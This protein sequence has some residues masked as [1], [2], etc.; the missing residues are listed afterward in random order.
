MQNGKELAC[1]AA[2]TMGRCDARPIKHDTLFNAFSVTKPV[3][4]LAIHILADQG[5]VAHLAFALCLTLLQN[6]KSSLP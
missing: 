4:A 5:R 2:G 3:A 1:L 6:L